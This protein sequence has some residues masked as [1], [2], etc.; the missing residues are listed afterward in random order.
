MH[1]DAFFSAFTSARLSAFH[2][3]DHVRAAWLCLR[4]LGLL[5]ALEAVSNGIR[6]LAEAQG[7]PAKYHATVSWLY[8]LVIHERMESD[9]SDTT[10]E[11][12]AT[13]NPD[14]FANWTP[15][16]GRYYTPERLR[17]PLARRTFVLPDRACPYGFPPIPRR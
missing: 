10:W 1:D 17:S 12:F 9:P 3:G 5:D 4:R 2:H 8:V 7:R 6:A 11:S 13:R 16:V 15:F 14:L